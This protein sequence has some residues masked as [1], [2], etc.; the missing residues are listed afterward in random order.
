MILYRPVGLEELRLVY[1][2]GLKAFPPR[3]PE[4]PIF[5][6][7]LNQPYATQIARD[8]NTKSPNAAGYVTE[9]EVD[10]EF[11]RR[12]EVQQVGAREHLELWVPAE[13]LPA[14]NEHILPPIRVTAAYFGEEFRGFVPSV[15][16]FRGK[17]ASSSS[18]CSI[19]CSITLDSTSGARSA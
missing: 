6:P 11:V 17:N 15:T 1:E 3:L 8:W 16:M 19:K 18:S 2:S 12:Y 5:Y 7:V 10:D 4:Q 14:F 9:F 13:D